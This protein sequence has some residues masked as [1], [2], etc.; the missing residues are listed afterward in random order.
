[1]HRILRKLAT[2]CDRERQSEQRL[3]VQTVRV[4]QIIPQSATQFVE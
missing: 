2:A 4:F 3:T 1:M